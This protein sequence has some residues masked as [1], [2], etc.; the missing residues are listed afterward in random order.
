MRA[1]WLSG[2]EYGK[3]AQHPQGETAGQ[4]QPGWQE[5]A[6]TASWLWGILLE[7]A[8]VPEKTEMPWRYRGDKNA[9]KG[10]WLWLMTAA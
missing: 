7:P 9:A 2:N 10:R 8:T 6:C 5:E 4:P 1:A 3:R